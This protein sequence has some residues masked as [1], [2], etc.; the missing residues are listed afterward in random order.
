MSL[1]VVVPLT[2]LLNLVQANSFPTFSVTSKTIPPLSKY[3]AVPAATK[4]L[5]L[6]SISGTRSLASSTAAPLLPRGYFDDSGEDSW[7]YQTPTSSDDTSSSD[8]TSSGSDSSN[9]FTYTYSQSSN[10]TYCHESYEEYCRRNEIDQ[11]DG[12]GEKRKKWEK[13]MKKNC[14]NWSD[15]NAGGG[16][17]GSDSGRTKIVQ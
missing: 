8:S 17:G 2:I 9:S 11:G 7:W 16:G 1:F 14:W 3:L 6:E 5:H 15:S 10:S 13:W 4:T 12:N